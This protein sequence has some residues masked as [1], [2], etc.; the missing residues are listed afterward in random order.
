MP[1]QGRDT[2]EVLA[3]FNILSDAFN[4]KVKKDPKSF[5]RTLFDDDSFHYDFF[6]DAR[7]KLTRMRYVERDT[8]KPIKTQPPCLTNLIKTIDGVQLLWKRL[9]EL[10]FTSLKTKHLNQDP[11]ENFFGLI[12]DHGAQNNKPTCYQFIGHFK[13]L[14]INNLTHYCIRGTNCEDDKGASLLTWKSYLVF[15]GEAEK[16][17]EAGNLCITP[18]NPANKDPKITASAT[19]IKEKFTVSTLVV[20]KEVR[21]LEPCLESCPEC[22]KLISSQSGTSSRRTMSPLNEMYN[23]VVSLL[24]RIM[25]SVYKKHQVIKLASNYLK[26]EI[27]SEI[28]TC[29]MHRES[30]I[31]SFLHCSIKKYITSTSAY[32]NLISKGKR[33][34]E[35]ETE[36]Y[37]LS[38]KSQ[39]ATNSFVERA[40]RKRQ[41]S[42]HNKR[43][44]F[45]KV[46]KG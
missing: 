13:A 37:G 12:R 4:G 28:A 2:A 24:K 9:K 20:L 21:A 19:P 23:D 41:S 14:V 16:E 1:I 29:R 45:N 38:E 8:K 18:Q 46:Q 42:L 3:Y 44:T 35:H 26:K 6:S 10:G 25:D 5:Y 32:L 22:I 27:H 43:K 40:V 11:L 15:V 17:T 33:K 36:K 30:L 39:Q 7:R 31:N 34:S